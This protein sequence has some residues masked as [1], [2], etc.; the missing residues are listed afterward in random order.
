MDVIVAIDQG[1]SSTK[2][3][4][5]DAQRR[6][7]V[8]SSVPVRSYRLGNNWVEFDVREVW[9]SVEGAVAE[10]VSKLPA[11]ARI[12]GVGVANQR[13]SAIAWRASDNEPIGSGISWQCQ[14]GEE[15]CEAVGQRIGATRYEQ[16]TGLRLSTAISAP[17]F[18]W[19][20][21]RVGTD[22][23]CVGTVD[24]WLAQWLTASQQARSE[25]GNGSRTGLV[26][27]RNGEWSPE[28]LDAFNIPVSCLPVLGPSIN[29]FG[30]CTRPTALRG[31]PLLALCGDSH[32]ALFSHFVRDPEVVKATYGTGSS[33]V[34]TVIESG[35]AWKNRVDTLSRSIVWRLDS[36]LYADEGNVLSAGSFLEW[37]ASLLG[38]ADV[39]ALE[40]LAASGEGS[41]DRV[42][43]IPALG[44][45]GAPWHAAHAR[46][47]LGGAGEAT[48]PK[49]IA[50]AAFRGVGHLVA[51]IA[52]PLME[53]REGARRLLVDGGASR[54]DLLMQSQADLLGVS[55]VRP[56]EASR[57]AVGVAYMAG[58][59]AGLWELEDLE[60]GDEPAVVFEPRISEDQ[61]ASERHRWRQLVGCCTSTA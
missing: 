44:G 47:M 16:L 43:M 25:S 36:P 57:S 52:E 23:V 38:A 4:A 33:V 3:L 24:A 34:G 41:G 1:S 2:V 60:C 17:K 10:C 54:S 29:Q 21:E 19:L 9:R 35:S 49:E 5:M 30:E 26:D 42:M 56:A 55:V 7:V 12:V 20:L 6:V 51:D 8:R 40:R 32:A 46:T 61:R 11:D 39:G 13:E 28:L 15:Y 31:V 58:L 50:F 22:D 37:A 45:L 48:G 14:R 59:G 18:A 53:C 27:L